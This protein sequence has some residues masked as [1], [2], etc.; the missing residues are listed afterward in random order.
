MY[1]IEKTIRS[2]SKYKGKVIN[3]RV[4]T[5]TAPNG[6]AIREIVEHRGAVAMIPVTAQGK[7]VLVR[8]FRKA[9]E[10]VLLEI[11]AG[12]L[13]KNEDH[14]KAAKRELKEE[15]GYT[16]EDISFMFSYY[17]CIGYS[18]EVIY[19]YLCKDLIPGET[20]FDEDEA[21][22]IEEYSLDELQ[23]MIESGE[24]KDGK[25]IVAIY[26]CLQNL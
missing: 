26:Y 14:F 17:P 25:T 11:P 23:K 21:I 9:A 8:Q 1:F 16:A 22:D 5:V 15:T 4:D 18:E 12:K 2:E 10:K 6:E 24:I 20:S 3:V 7:I 13:E 19:M